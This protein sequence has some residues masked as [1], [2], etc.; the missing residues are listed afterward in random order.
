MP[1]DDTAPRQSRV[2]LFRGV[3]WAG[4]AV[5]GIAVLLLLLGQDT[6]QLRLAVVLAVVAISL[7][8]VSI[9]FRR[10]SDT[11][12]GEVEELILEEMDQ[13][14]EDVREDITSAARA[15]HKAL[16]DKVVQLNDTVETLRTELD[17]LRAHLEH[18][19]Q[20]ALTSAPAGNGSHSAGGMV[21]HTETVQVTTRRTILDPNEDGRGTVYGASGGDG[22]VPSQRRSEWAGSGRQ[23]AQLGMENESWTDQL[24]RER[25]SGGRG[26]E[27]DDA[28]GIR[29]VGVG[30]RWASVRDT[31]RGQEL[32]M[33]DRWTAVHADESGTE[34]HIGDRWAAVL[35]DGGRDG[36]RDEGQHEPERWNPGH[37][38]ATGA[39]FDGFR[40]PQDPNAASWGQSRPALP[41]APAEPPPSQY[42]PWGGRGEPERVA[43]SGSASTGPSS[44]RR[45]RYEDEG[46][47]AHRRSGRE[48]E[49]RDDRRGDDR[50]GEDRWGADDWRG[51]SWG[52]PA[53]A[54]GTEPSV[55]AR[56][57]R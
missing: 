28:D 3:F 55:G 54:R 33:G 20:P 18:G 14:H 42:S 34:V 22:R 39:S 5:A 6:L 4:I 50:R 48:D 56:D 12:R 29:G 1:P 2:R 52:G 15:T 41:A 32:R 30:D 40:V 38:W 8:G 51:R 36:G 17:N 26:G 25:F 23:P 11:V 44:S 24:L 53:T 46:A 16:G 45:G 47:D 37:S 49:W 7:I 35:R 27:R 19:V 57:P 10:E 9:M 21:R 43:Y 13:L 31:E